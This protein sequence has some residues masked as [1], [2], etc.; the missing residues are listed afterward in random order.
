MGT[1]G[2]GSV[3][4]AC[5]MPGH[6][7][8]GDV[9]RCWGLLRP[10]EQTGLLRVSPH[11]HTERMDKVLRAELARRVEADQAM[12][13][14]WP[15]RPGDGADEDELARLGA[16]DEDNTAWLRSV[17][18]KHGWPDSSLVGEA[19]AHDAWLLAQ[20][21]DQDRVFQAE[22]LEPTAWASCSPNRSPNPT[23]STNGEPPP[24][25]DRSTSTRP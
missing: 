1:T 5:P 23:V 16:V 7:D 17:V 20:H 19:G 11:L 3:H 14:A 9:I 6:R 22:C 10:S 2:T 15:A 18:A 4:R 24:G 13:R 25:S 8:V 21:A 12:R